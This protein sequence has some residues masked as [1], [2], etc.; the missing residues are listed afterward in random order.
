MT[1][2]GLSEAFVAGARNLILNCAEVDSDTK[3]LIIS[4]PPGTGYYDDKIG[5]GVAAVAE[6]I[7]GAVELL[8][9]P[10]DPVARDPDPDLS[11]RMDAA[12]RVIFFAR[13][14]DQLRFRPSMGGKFSVMS[15]A[16]DSDML[17]SSFGRIPHQAMTELRSLLNTA[18]AAASEIRVTCP[19]GTDF[20]GPGALFP[21]VGG[22]TYVRRF[23]VSVFS[24]IPA[25]GF[26]GRIA[27]NGFLCGTGSQTYEP[28]ACEIAETLIVE[29]D[30][31]HIKNFE[32]T[33]SD[34]ASASDHYSHVAEMFGLEKD[35]IHSWH[36]GIH[37]ALSYPLTANADFDR[38][39]GG[40]FGNPRL[41]H[42]HTC[43]AQPPGEISLNIV[44][45]TIRLDGVAV[46]ENGRLH[47]DRVPGGSDFLE[48]FPEL[49]AQFKNPA[50]EIGTGQSGRLEY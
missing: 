3:V 31:N 16:L 15:Y 48:A 32:G 46:W 44:D 21:E 41:M 39:S 50:I 30:G 43:G 38:W 12:D 29:F 13:L 36:A 42:F 26:V 22:E 23:P 17:A 9:L 10:F 34:I 45:P 14:G 25:A 4:E 33:K 5:P 6:G 27:Q 11:K 2:S 18:L 40:A 35:F 8:E 49:A 28:P 24:P 1:A 37:P 7:A 20:S 19:A 47:P